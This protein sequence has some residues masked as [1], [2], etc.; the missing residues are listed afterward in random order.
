MAAHVNLL[1]KNVT[2]NLMKMALPLM[3]LNLINS[4]G[5]KRDDEPDQ[6]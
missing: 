3:F 6:A 5:V 4:L 1:D 2:K